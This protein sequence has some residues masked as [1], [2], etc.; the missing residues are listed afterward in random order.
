M[1]I[2]SIAQTPYL[3]K[4]SHIFSAILIF[5]ETYLQLIATNCFFVARYISV[6]RNETCSCVFLK[7]DWNSTGATLLA[8]I[9]ISTGYFKR[10]KRNS[11]ITHYRQCK[12]QTSSQ[13][14]LSCFLM[15]HYVSFKHA[16]ATGRS[17]RAQS[18]PELILEQSNSIGNKIY[19][20][21]NS[22]KKKYIWIKKRSHAPLPWTVFW[23]RLNNNEYPNTI[24]R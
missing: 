10:N 4:T 13:I 1:Y 14:S 15:A 18:H 23:E 16:R 12:Y 5:P 8:K 20:G 22:W 3:R 9:K 7:M 17:C 6:R 11:H 2:P 19:T 24:S 21:F